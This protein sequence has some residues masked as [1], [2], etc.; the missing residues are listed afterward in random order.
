MPPKLSI[1][2]M[3]FGLN[4]ASL[5]PYSKIVHEDRDRNL[6]KVMLVFSKDL[7]EKMID[8]S[9]VLSIPIEEVIAQA[10]EDFYKRLFGKR[11][12]REK[13]IARK[14]QP[15]K[16]SNLKTIRELRELVSVLNSLIGKLNEN[17]MQA[18]RISDII[19]QASVQTMTPVSTV[20]SRGSEIRE[21]ELPELK[22]IESTE[23]NQE[24]RKAK[25]SLEETLEDILVVAVA[26]DLLKS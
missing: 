17:I 3:G 8:A 24:E 15:K 2:Y 9:E 10:F 1:N 12:V 22:A 7:Y 13:R 19:S 25:K 21:I 4:Y 23:V 18:Q 11:A 20:K 5:D 16:A 14:Q 6:V 26:E